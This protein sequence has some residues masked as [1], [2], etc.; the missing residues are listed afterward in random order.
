[1]RAPNPTR[2]LLTLLLVVAGTQLLTTW[3]AARRSPPP[4]TRLSD[5]ASL[6]DPRAPSLG[7]AAADV[8]IILFSD[9]ACGNCRALHADLRQLLADDPGVRIVYRDWPI[10]GARS[11][12]A[13]RLALASAAQGR[14]AAFD[15]ALMRHGGRLDDAALRAAAV[16][17][18]VDWP[19]LEADLKRQGDDIDAL[20]AANDRQAR[21]LSFIGTPVVA[22]GPYLV[23]GRI[24]PDRLRM[25]VA[26]AR[27][28]PPDLGDASVTP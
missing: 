15:D 19:R 13:A 28:G 3:L 14:H 4:P 5:P 24:A 25:L 26:T 16:D 8:T 7:S 21:G 18:R 12:R 17:A 22:V 6:I 23:V 2:M 27:G 9:Y 11:V 1:M 10:L 20:L